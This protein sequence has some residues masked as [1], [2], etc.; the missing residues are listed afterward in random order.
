MAAT[1]TRRRGRC[2]A[3]PA[4]TPCTW[5]RSSPSATSPIPS[6]PRASRTSFER[7]RRKKM[8]TKLNPVDIVIVG[9]GWT[10]GILAKELAS[11]GLKIVALERGG[12]RSTDPDF[13]DPQ[14]HDEVRYAIRYE[15]FQNTSKETLTFRN[16]S[17]Q[18]ALPMRKLGS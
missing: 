2:S 18:S 4:P 11:T 10:G 8:A 15:M 3:S 5:I 17:G 14:V 6:R 1:R 13:L 12:P 16:N 9:F 7:R